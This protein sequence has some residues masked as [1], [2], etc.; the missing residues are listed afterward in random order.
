M[1]RLPI[2]FTVVIC[3]LF[4]TSAQ[5]KKERVGSDTSNCA[6]VL[7]IEQALKMAK[8]E[9]SKNLDPDDFFIDS[10]LLQCHQLE[11]VWE[12]GWRRKAYQSGH[13]LMYIHKNGSIQQ[14]VVKD[15]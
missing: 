6:P 9:L 4:G 10:V 5:A 8:N 2:I 15:G 1:R 11:A 3:L 13:L 12:V 7:S 14:S